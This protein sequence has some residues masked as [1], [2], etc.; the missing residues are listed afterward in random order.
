VG[1]GLLFALTLPGLV[2]VLVV[3]AVV[4]R[5]LSQ[6]KRRSLVRGQERPGLSA[7]GIDVF[8]A[9]LSPGKA[10]EMEQRRVEQLLREEEGD[11]APPR[12]RIDFERRVAY[13]RM[14]LTPGRGAAPSPGGGTPGE[15]HARFTAP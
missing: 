12:D 5:S 8:S 11:G 15:V 7:G 4:E 6:L 14:S 2:I 3:L 10:T 9:A 1:A 13:L